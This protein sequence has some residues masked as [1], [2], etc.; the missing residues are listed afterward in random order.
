M[1]SIRLAGF[2]NASAADGP[3]I[4]SVLFVQGCSRKCYGCHNERTW[5]INGGRIMS[6][7]VLM[8][9][10][11]AHC[12]TRK[13]TISGGEPLEQ[14]CAIK[15]LLA[16]L[17]DAHFDICLYTG[18]ELNEVP[19][20]IISALHYLKV[21]QYRADLARIQKPFV[22]SSNQVFYE[23]KRNGGKICLKEI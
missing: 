2:I 22:G 15:V 14:S 18:Y 17:S 4:R 9:Y 5:N 11:L 16:A 8:K 10:I 13:I 3:G 23:V 1:D 6:V 19:D 12:R 20:N 7:P 21:G